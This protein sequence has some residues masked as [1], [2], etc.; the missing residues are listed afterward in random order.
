MS[1]HLVKQ[2]SFAE[3]LRPDITPEMG[4]QSYEMLSG[5]TEYRKEQQS[6]FLEGSIRNPQ[7]DYPNIDE[8]LLR[9]GIVTLGAIL[10]ESQTVEDI[11]ARDAIWDTTGYR[12]AEMYWLLQAKR[13]NQLAIDAPNSEEFYEAA[14]R[15]Q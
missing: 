2:N 5:N 11:E 13:L 8:A 14:G 9:Q 1:E 15:Y 7:L 12:M 4:F 3:K 6:A 10:V